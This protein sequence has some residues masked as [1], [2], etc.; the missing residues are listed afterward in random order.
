MA[1]SPD[2]KQIASGS[3]DR[4]IKVW[5]TV[6][7][8]VKKTLIGHWA[9]VKTIAFSLNGK[10]IAS[11]S[12]MFIMV[13]DT[14]TGNIEKGLHG[15]FSMVDAVAFSP[16]GKRIASS[17]GCKIMVW[18]AATG[19]LEKERVGHSSFITAVAFSPDGKWIALGSEDKTIKVWDVAEFIK[20]SRSLGRAIAVAEVIDNLKFSSDSQH[21]LTNIG[22]ILVESILTPRKRDNSESSQYLYVNDRW[23]CYKAVPILRL[24]PDSE[25]T[26]YDTRE[27]QVAVGFATGRVL[28][29]DIDRLRLDSTLGFS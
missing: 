3:K 24:Q 26:C 23:L 16:D 7:G 27:D 5:D 19:N 9:E 25:L 1:F 11:G 8:D 4:K 15:H 2:G 28:S 14:A 10:R 20:N 22:P 18:D 29:F 6:T 13:W 17:A 21:L 12:Y